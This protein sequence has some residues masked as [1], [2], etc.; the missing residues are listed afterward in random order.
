MRTSARLMGATAVA[1]GLLAVGSPG[2]AADSK[3]EDN[4]SSVTIA[5]AEGGNGGHG[6]DGGKG[7]FCPALV[8]G[9][10]F[11]GNGGSADGGDANATAEDDSKDQEAEKKSK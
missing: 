8:F 4:H 6:G 3:K 9:N 5:A 7:N 1:V 11:C 2:F 10:A